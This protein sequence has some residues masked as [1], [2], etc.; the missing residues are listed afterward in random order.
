MSGNPALRAWDQGT[1]GLRACISM[2]KTDP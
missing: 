1:V 2:E